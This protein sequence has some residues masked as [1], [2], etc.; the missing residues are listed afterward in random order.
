[1]QKQHLGFLCRG[2]WT[3]RKA[4]EAR[5]HGGSPEINMQIE[6]GGKKIPIRST[7]IPLIENRIKNMKVI[8]FEP[9]WFFLSDFIVFC[10]SEFATFLFES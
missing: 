8:C 1:M 2:K 3:G 7:G 10:I 5:D 9:I 6:K 4:S